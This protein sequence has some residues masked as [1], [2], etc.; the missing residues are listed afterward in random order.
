V[1]DLLSLFQGFSVVLSWYNIW[2]MAIGLFLGIVVGV[3]PGLGGPNGVAI[4][5]PLTFT[6]PP[7]S[8]IIMLSCIYWGSLFAGAITSVLFNQ[9]YVIQSAIVW[10]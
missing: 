5:L 10:R 8:A 1:S 2:M 9:G 4:L 6:M 3:L 7:T